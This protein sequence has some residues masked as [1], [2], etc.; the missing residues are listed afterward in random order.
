M[1][2]RPYLFWG[3]KPPRDLLRDGLG[4]LEREVMEVLWRSGASTVRDVHT[5]LPEPIAYTTVMTTLDRLFKKRL[6]S[7]S[8]RGRA[9]VY[10]AAGSRQ[11]VETE[12]AGEVVRAC[13]TT[14]GAE[15]VLSHLVE[16]VSDR[17]RAWLDELERL[18]REKRRALALDDKERVP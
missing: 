1:T 5:V 6:V 17:D 18:I 11:E 8:R 2:H 15:P 13:L 12:I 7:R 9:F 10:E 16:A 14:A 3:F 4:P